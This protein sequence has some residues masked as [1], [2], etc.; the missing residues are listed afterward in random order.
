M[1]V[2]VA[3][4]GIST[5]VPKHS[6]LQ[7]EAAA[8]ATEL[9]VTTKYRKSLDTMYRMAGVQNR[10]SVIL[11]SSSADGAKQSFYYKSAGP[12]DNG[13]TTS[14]RMAKYEK[15]AADLAIEAST[16]AIEAS[17]VDK[18]S[19]THLV[20]ISCSGFAAPGVDL[21]LIQRLGLS[22]DVE[23]AHVGFMGCHG[24]LNGLRVA[25]GWAAADPNAKVLVC[26]VELCS[27]HHQYT[28][29]A[30]QLVANALF[31][32]GS[33]AFIVQQENKH[34][35]DCRLVAQSSHVIADTED[36]MSWKIADNGFQ[37]TLSP[38]V[39]EVI[40]NTLK[41]WLSGW[42]AKCGKTIE[43]IQ[44]WAVHPGGP[45][46]LT[47]TVEALG[48]ESNAVQHSEAIL[49]SYGNMSSPTVFFILERIRKMNG[50]GPTVI[51][52]FG[53]GLTIEAA[54][55]EW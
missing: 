46:I 2:T 40:V 28:E 49:A 10:H 1:S 3:V 18:A 52:G 4:S 37:M 6:I 12:E 48:L 7:T 13:P 31:S 16:K 55:L 11:D 8:M 34:D 25:R 22:A 21:A 23:R 42:L 5:A 54:L 43:D 32:D 20:T 45:R 51:L 17:G 27:L 26:A 14:Y 30:Q 47:A 19:I 53:P 33:C 35:T 38:R 44:S 15:C 41:P 39:P 29:H 50:K 36:M 9:G 24:A